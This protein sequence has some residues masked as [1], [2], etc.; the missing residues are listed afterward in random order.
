[1]GC[2]LTELLSWHSTFSLLMIALQC[3]SERTA[4][5]LTR[6]QTPSMQVCLIPCGRIAAQSRTTA[7]LSLAGLCGSLLPTR[8]CQGARHDTTEHELS[9][10]DTS[11]VTRLQ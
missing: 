5:S 3:S 6:A 11:S 9:G 10:S 1:M 4:K 8:S 2:I 7:P